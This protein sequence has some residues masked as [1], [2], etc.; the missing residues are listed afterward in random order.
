[1][2]KAKQK[3]YYFT[4]LLIAISATT[5]GQNDKRVFIMVHFEAGRDTT[6]PLIN[7][8]V[9]NELG[10]PPDSLLNNS[11]TFQQILWPSIV[12]M[13]QTADSFDI[14]LTLALQSQ[15]AEYI[16]QD[17]D[18]INIF[19]EWVNNGHEL[20]MHHHG[21]NHIDW[22]GYTNRFQGTP[23]PD[24]YLFLDRFLNSGLFRG[25]MQESFNYLQQLAIEVND[26]VV[27]GCITDTQIDKPDEII[28][29][30]DGGDPIDLISIPDTVSLPNE[31]FYFLSHCQLVSVYKDGNNEIIE[32]DIINHQ[33][34]TERLD[35]IKA[36]LNQLDDNEV[37]GIVFHAFDYYRFP[38]IY[39]DLFIFFDQNQVNNK[40]IKGLMNETNTGI[41][42]NFSNENI[43]IYPNPTNGIV[44]IQGKNIQ[45]IELINSRGQIIK[46]ME[47]EEGR[48]II[49]L[50]QQPKGIYFVKATVDNSIVIKK[51]VIE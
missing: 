13:V 44:N 16:L 9:Y 32:D 46:Q 10:F 18:K 22:G 20:A 3:I 40:S 12:D 39:R 35:L 30:T 25:N 51:I 41:N 47:F 37:M 27:T 15:M 26:S 7:Q 19:N 8:I 17:T 5:F 2:N 38:D 33:Y 36:N 50:S 14:K 42:I 45:E 21:I 48:L 28:Y 1:M 49:D 31:T 43:K 24:D 4:L 11:L 34:A 29:L 6:H 23:Y